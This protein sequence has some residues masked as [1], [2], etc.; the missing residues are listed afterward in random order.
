[1]NLKAERPT[2]KQRW[3]TDDILDLMTEG[4]LH[5]N[6]NPEQYRRLNTEVR[7]RIKRAKAD[8]YSQ[9]CTEIEEFGRKYDMFN[10]HKKVKQNTGLQEWQATNGLVD[11]SGKNILAHTMERICGATL[12]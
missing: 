3:M 4:A 8:W 1:M 9:E 12:C 5:R 11:E 6:K 2:R 10:L 7:A